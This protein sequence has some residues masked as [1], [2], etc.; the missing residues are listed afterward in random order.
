MLISIEGPSLEQF[1]FA[2]ADKWGK[3]KNR[4]I[5]WQT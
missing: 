4:R 5:H 2:T 3:L 1:N